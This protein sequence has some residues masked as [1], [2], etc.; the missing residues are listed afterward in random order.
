MKEYKANA[1]SENGKWFFRLIDAVTW[2]TV[3]LTES[4]YCKCLL[5]GIKTF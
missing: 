4:Q 5:H 3:V 2:N 1:F